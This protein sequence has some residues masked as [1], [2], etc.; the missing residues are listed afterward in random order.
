MD[1]CLD[2]IPVETLIPHGQPMVYLD[3]I[4]DAGEHWLTAS[5]TVRDQADFMEPEGVPSWVGLEYLGQA[6]AALAGVEARRNH[7]PVQIGFLVSCRRYAPTLSHFPPGAR[8]S[9]HV[10]AATFNAT[11]LRVFTGRIDCDGREAVNAN[12]NVYMPDDVGQFME[13]N[14]REAEH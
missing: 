12:L 11:G 4:D 2:Q 8:L 10:E 13:Q 7:T 1:R 9:I 3:R 6:I 5:L 14:Q